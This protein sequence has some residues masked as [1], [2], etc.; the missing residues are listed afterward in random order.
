[1]TIEATSKETYYSKRCVNYFQSWYTGTTNK[2]LQKAIMET[3]TQQQATWSGCCYLLSHSGWKLP[4]I[5]STP[6]IITKLFKR[7]S[8]SNDLDGTDDGELWA[9]QH[10]KYDTDSDEEDDDMYDG[11]PTDKTD[12]Q[13]SEWWWWILGV[14]I[15]IADF[16]ASYMRVRLRVDLLVLKIGASYMRVQLIHR[17]IRYSLQRLY[18]QCFFS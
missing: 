2:L 11:K 7:Y 12:L 9:E 16:S 6:A 13:G 5:K 14:L 1:M 18:R 15:N 3:N 8:I 4:G 17:Y 10:N